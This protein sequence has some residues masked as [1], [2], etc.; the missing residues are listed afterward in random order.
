MKINQ[1][2]NF[3]HSDTQTS[4]RIKG[5]LNNPLLLYLH[6]GIGGNCSPFIHHYGKSL[7]KNYLMVYWDQRGC[8]LSPTYLNQEKLSLNLFNEDLNEIIIHLKNKFNKPIFLIGT[9]WGGTL[10]LMYLSKY[11]HA[12]SLISIGGLANVT[13]ASLYFFNYLRNLIINKIN[14][15]NNSADKAKWNDIYNLLHEVENPAKFKYSDLKIIRDIIPSE[16][17]FSVTQTDPSIQ[18]IP[19]HDE[20]IKLGY[21]PLD[22]KG[23]ALNKIFRNRNEFAALDISEEIKPITTPVMIIQGEQ[24]HIAGF[25]QGELIYKSLINCKHKQL[26]MIKGEGHR[27]LTKK[28]TLIKYINE[29]MLKL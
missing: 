22:Q 9:S 17:N 10:G 20:L 27:I 25:K 12:E 14:T 5:D 4:L 15:S 26:K 8:G 24:D 28:R 2:Y 18:Y 6:G 23:R 1:L 29:F 16:L 19:N 11:N 7:E 21:N 3:N 13:Y